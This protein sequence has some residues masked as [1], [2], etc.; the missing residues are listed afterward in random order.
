MVV[1]QLIQGLKTAVK[2]SLHGAD[3]RNFLL[4]T[5]QKVW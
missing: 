3:H 5:L 1:G 4:C 2:G